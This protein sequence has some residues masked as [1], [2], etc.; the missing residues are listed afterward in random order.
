MEWNNN[1]YEYTRQTPIW[2]DF[3]ATELEKIYNPIS[4][5]TDQ[6]RYVLHKDLLLYDMNVEK[7]SADWERKR[8]YRGLW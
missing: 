1:H 4:E 5:L 8:I 7:R 6:E 2:A 3:K